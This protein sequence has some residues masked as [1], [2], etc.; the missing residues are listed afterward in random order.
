MHTNIRRIREEQFLGIPLVA[1]LVGV[2]SEEYKTIEEARIGD[3][4]NSILNRLSK[5]FGVAISDIPA[6]NVTPKTSI[7]R[8]SENDNAQLQKLYYY[9]ERDKLLNG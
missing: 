2:T 1:K 6:T 8:L 7:H 9:R 4:D 3:I 5:L